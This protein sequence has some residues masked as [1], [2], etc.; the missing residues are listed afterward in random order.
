[1]GSGFVWQ[2]AVALGRNFHDELESFGERISLVDESGE[3]VT[4]TD[5]ARRAD[6]IASTFGSGRRLIFIECENALEPVIA[7]LGALRKRHVVL[8]IPPGD[9][10]KL[11]PLLETY[12]PDVRIWLEN[13]V[14]TYVVDEQPER[15][16][17]PDLALLLSTSGST[18]A[19]KLA[20]L[21]RVAVSANAAAVAEYMHVARDDTAIT[22]IPI[23]FSAGLLV[24][25]SHLTRGARILLTGRSVIDP[26][27]WSSA[28]DNQATTLCG[29]PYTFEL[30][31]RIGFRD[32]APPSIHTLACSGGRLPADLAR[33]YA[34][35]TRSRDISLYLT[36]GQTEAGRV[37][38]LPPEQVLDHLESIGS[39]LP[40]GRMWLVDETG[41]P[42]EA[43]GI[44]GELVCAGPG[45]M[46]GYA[47]DA[48]DLALG[49]DVE[50]LR[51]GDIAVKD[52]DG[53]FTIRG[54][55]SRFVK[56]FSVRISLDAVEQ[57]LARKGYRAAV[58]GDDS[59]LAVCVIQPADPGHLRAELARSFELP[60][61]VL[62]ITVVDDLPLLPSGKTDY[63]GLLR[64]AQARRAT[65]SRESRP[66][67]E[68]ITAFAEAFPGRTIGPGDS[69]TSLGG[70]SLSYV[71]LSIQIED[72]LGRLP[73]R[74]EEQTVGELSGQANR[75]PPASG[76]MRPREIE[77][78]TV[79]RALSICLVVIAH[80]G[81]PHPPMGGG[82]EV[83]LMLSGYYL[84]RHQRARLIE[85]GG[86]P[87]LGSF[88]VRIIAPYYALMLTWMAVKRD[89]DLP[90]LL[91]VSA[92]RGRFHSLLEP[93]W[94]LETLLQ[95]FVIVAAA[96]AIPQVRRFARQRPA[97]SAL[98]FLSIAVM[99]KIILFGVFD[100][101]ALRDRTVD[102]LIYL[103]AFGWWLD[104][105]TTPRL[106]L[107]AS[108]LAL[109]LGGLDLFGLP[110]VWFRYEPPV[111]LTH[112][113]W[114]IV[115]ALALIWT[116][117]VRLP[118]P[119][120]RLVGTIGAA[121]FYIYLAH[122]VPLHLMSWQFHMRSLPAEFCV[123]VGSGILL[124][125][126]V[127]WLT[128]RNRLGSRLPP[129]S[130]AM[131]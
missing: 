85:G 15:S 87:L 39:A 16:F 5:L 125:L 48:A 32:R 19:V 24:V 7:Y 127:R 107:A 79:L 105:A 93:Y 95:C 68:V 52:S 14:W 28:Q 102:S 63:V 81:L 94:F 36:F 42:I 71:R 103:Y 65:P 62:D 17:H 11:Q 117:K 50:E 99:V 51:T 82:V 130:P 119:V 37:A 124:W 98:A 84:S 77:V 9:H 70:D 10:H 104:Q 29:V 129:E 40:G 46:M 116:P 83:L 22:V 80:S 109:I 76:W 23:H 92:F 8:L 108:I 67:P 55:R 31:D 60:Q 66:S 56:L 1:M 49:K 38:Y 59:L 43:A 64:S 26:V 90:S 72:A 35:W 12:R 88:L 96:T 106:R 128:D 115:A 118:S 114:L 18:G 25:N 111:N 112:A 89:W 6:A 53:F 45:I 97:A 33:T 121:S 30:L 131:A 110:G 44:E 58:A 54:R 126:G 21:S 120:Q 74:W 61:T 4:Y 113:A 57:N 34:L 13:G 2:D 100:H 123:A 27:F 122:G 101:H 47:N 73:E 41:R 75:S 78:G 20:R 3:S 91:L 69:F 86:W